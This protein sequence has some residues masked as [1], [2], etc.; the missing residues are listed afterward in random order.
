MLDRYSFT[1]PH[2]D[3]HMEISKFLFVRLYNLN[4]VIRQLSKSNY[5]LTQ[6]MIELLEFVRDDI[7]KIIN[8]IKE[9]NKSF[10]VDEIFNMLVQ[11]QAKQ[12]FIKKNKRLIKR[13]LRANLVK[14]LGDK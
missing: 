10:R 12:K 8:S 14:Y 2:K 4:L 5:F 13:L 7:E 11:M 9:Q 1:Q 6:R 3:K